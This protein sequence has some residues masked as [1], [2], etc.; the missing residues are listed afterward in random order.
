MQRKIDK[1]KQCVPN[2]LLLVCKDIELPGNRYILR[3]IK[4]K[5]KFNVPGKLLKYVNDVTIKVCISVSVDDSE[6]FKKN[7]NINLNIACCRVID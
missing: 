5:K 7:K 3:N 2:T 4:G 6:I 1:F